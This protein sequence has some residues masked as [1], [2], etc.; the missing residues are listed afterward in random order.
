MVANVLFPSAV[1]VD[2]SQN[3]F[4]ADVI[5]RKVWKVA[6]GGTMTTFAGTGVDG[7]AGDGGQATA[8]QL[9]DPQSL[10][11][12][13]AGNVYIGDH[14]GPEGGLIRKVTPDGVITT[15]AGGGR[16]TGDEVTAIG[17][18]IVPKGIAVDESGDIFIADGGAQVLEVTPDGIL[19]RIAGGNLGYWGDGGPATLAGMRNPMGIAVDH[20][21]NIYVAEW[22]NN[23][24]RVLR[25][26][27][28]PVLVSAVL[29]AATESAIPVTPGKIVA[30]YGGGLGPSD[31]KLNSPEKGAFGTAVAGTS[32]TFNG[33]PAPMIYSSAGQAAAIVPYGVAGAVAAQVVVSS[34]LGTSAPY[35][36]KIAAAA[37]SFFSQNSTGAGQVAAVNLDGT[38]NDAA[39]PVRAGDFISL[40]ATGEGQT[41]PA[42]K[43]GALAMDVL[44]KP[45]LPVSVSVDGIAVTPTYAGAAPTEVSGLMQ[46]VI[47]IPSG[48][49]PGGYVPVAVKVGNGSTV[50]GSA[51]IAVRQ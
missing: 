29:D 36:V 19:H 18:A 45:V 6:P 14:G 9:F 4:V 30:I 34:S 44:P 33:L 35:T 49:K 15:V 10:A 37:P 27:N 24:V 46:V 20:A 23:I 50:E 42:G 28:A 11:V 5:N 26:T 3:I 1:A 51:W 48:V 43:D 25:P 22:G 12:D 8:A 2:H 32:V 17:A 41:Y 7:A 38:L 31:L 47:Q 40:Y 13:H 21:G 39:H 16:K